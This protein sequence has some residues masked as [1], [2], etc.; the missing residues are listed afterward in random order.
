MRKPEQ[1]PESDWFSFTIDITGGMEDEKET[2][3]QNAF[4]FAGSRTA[5]QLRNRREKGSSPAGSL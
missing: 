3:L 1:S 4:R 5:L 2:P